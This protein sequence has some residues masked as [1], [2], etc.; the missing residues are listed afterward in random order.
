MM[1]DFK[2]PIVDFQQE[3]GSQQ[4]F[5]PT[6]LLASHGS[7]WDTVYL[8]HHRN[9]HETP[10][11]YKTSHVVAV[12]LN[13]VRNE[14]WLEGR[15][16]QDWTQEGSVGIYPA[17]VL[18]RSICRETVE[19][20]AIAIEPGFLSGIAQEW[21]DPASVALIPQTPS[22]TDPLLLNMGLAL[23]REVENECLGSRLYGDSIATMLAVHLLR[24][25]SNLTPQ[26]RHDLDRFSSCRLKQALD[27]IHD[28]LAEDISLE[29]ISQYLGMSCYYFAR[30]FKQSMGVSPYQYV[31]QQR[32]EYAKRLLKQD[33]KPI[34]DIALESGF[35]SQSQMTQHFRKLTGI[36]PRAYR[37]R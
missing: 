4:L 12:I 3:G 31:L 22:Q 5:A 9:T 20:L 27:Y 8:E 25:Y 29:D 13:S 17:D 36:T 34:A 6:P 24:N 26:I 23:K 14:N 32:V 1:K 2:I 28:R 33:G 35:S 37:C 30:W 19:F 10:E 16:H 11:H 7:A 18:H 21:A 15:Y